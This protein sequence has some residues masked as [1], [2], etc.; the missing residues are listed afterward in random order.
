M[1]LCVTVIF[2]I[3]QLIHKMLPCSIHSSRTMILYDTQLPPGQV[4]GHQKFSTSNP[5][6]QR[7]HH[8]GGGGHHGHDGGVR[9]V[10]QLRAHQP[11]PS[12]TLP[13]TSPSQTST[14]DPLLPQQNRK[15]TVYNAYLSVHEKNSD[16]V[17]VLEIT[18]NH[19]TLRQ[20]KYRIILSA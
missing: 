17:Q 16:L 14:D 6:R 18:V 5:L 13:A 2:C 15:T 19:R 12:T 10:R 20:E 7:R 8:A 1:K 3:S 9:H 11:Q 4:L